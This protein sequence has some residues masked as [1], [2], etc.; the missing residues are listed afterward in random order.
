MKSLG[1][2]DEDNRQKAIT[3]AFMNI[4]VDEKKI[5]N[6]FMDCP[7]EFQE[8]PQGYYAW[9]MMQPEYFH[10]ICKEIMNVTLLPIQCA[11]LR[12]MW[13]HKFPM[14]IGS[15][16][17]GKSYLLAIYS[18][19]RILMLPNRKVVV[20]GAAF[21]QSKIIFEYM[22][23][24]WNNAPILRDMVGNPNTNG[25]R[26][27]SD[28]FRFFIG[29]S[30]VSALP[31][32]TGDKIRGQ[33]ANDI[34]ADEFDAIPKAIFETVIGGFAAVSSN[35]ITNVMNKASEK[36]A[37]KMGVPVAGGIQGVVDNQ[38]IISGTAGYDFSH[39]YEYWNNWKEIIQTGG[40][41]RKMAAYL[42]KKNPDGF[43]DEDSVPESFKPSDYCIIRI[44]YELIPEGF[45]D[46]ATVAR[47]KASIHFGTYL[48]EYGACFTKDSNG[49]YK[50]SLIQGCTCGA[51][52][53]PIILP[54][55]PINFKASIHG[56]PA[57]KYVYGIDPAAEVD[58]FAIT[59]L[60]L[61]PD[62]RRVVYTW[63]T[64][65]KNQKELL[66]LGE[67][68]ERDYY[69]YCARKIRDLMKK[70]TCAGI[71]I[72]SQGGGL[73]VMERLN[74]TDKMKPGE[75]FIWPLINPE[76]PLPTDSESGLHIINIV[77]F[78]SAEW[79]TNAN[80]NMKLD[81]ETRN[82]LF[83]YFDAIELVVEQESYD[84]VTGHDSLESCML[85]LEELK[86]ELATIVISKT[87][88]GRY[89]WD[90]PE[91]KLPGN[92]KGRLRKDRYSALLMANDLGRSIEL[93]NPKPLVCTTD[94]AGFA[95]R[96]SGES[97][98]GPMYRGNSFLAE[99]LTALYSGGV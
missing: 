49:F 61:H 31:I 38:T 79:T 90:T 82:L 1:K 88:T 45:M 26:R 87:P 74:D 9:L 7:E 36:L 42:N 70:F 39:F 22:E 35:P 20:C 84:K 78:S 25:P 59:I 89:K 80:H 86:S 67:T 47:A 94:G 44:P 6:P 65:K 54:S 62:H 30:R 75:Q 55:G 2:I 53:N 24:I 66:S 64:N 99:K 10:F 56:N 46:A 81:M 52:E 13:R 72:D 18:M 14:L 85:E 83:P 32:G 27:E 40:D 98:S 71:A 11:V 57:A 5:F 92:K 41:K 17:F 15:R 60:E 73:A 3:E 4:Y 16:G 97:I 51:S 33:R 23:T 34:I 8:E 95:E 68:S 48:C 28:M 77:N 76:K 93:Y 37:K 19:L 12:E 63:T 69:S 29:E 58:N 43:L 96:F 21:R 50:R 91:I